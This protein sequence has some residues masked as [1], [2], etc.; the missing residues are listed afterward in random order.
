[1]LEAHHLISSLISPVTILVRVTD[2]GC[3]RRL[4]ILN[5]RILN[6]IIQKLGMFQRQMAL[7]TAHVDN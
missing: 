6:Y 3:K 7:T 4:N 2:R 5:F 1:M